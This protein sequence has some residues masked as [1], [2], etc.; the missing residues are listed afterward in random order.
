MDSD[1]T[2][3]KDEMKSKLVKHPVEASDTT[4]KHLDQGGH[5]ETMKENAVKMETTQGRNTA[6]FVNVSIGSKSLNSRTYSFELNGV[7]KT[8]AN[9]Q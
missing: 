7:T 2:G 5:A 1:E 6:F 9:L 4:P 3:K 8:V